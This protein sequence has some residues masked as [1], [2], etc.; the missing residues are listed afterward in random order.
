MLNKKLIRK[1]TL[2]KR[3]SIDPEKKLKKDKLIMERILSL[4]SFEKAKKVFYFASFRS[5]VST[6]PQIEEAFKMGKRIILPKVDNINNRLRL[7][8]IH[9]T[10]EIKPGFMGI[11]EPDVSLERERDINDV[12]LVIMPGVA[13]DTDGNR[14]GYGAGYYDKLLSGLKKD[15]PLIAIAYEE[16]IVDS[17]PVE[18]HDVRVHII[19]TDKRIIKVNPNNAQG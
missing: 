13:F 15:I 10:G 14:L 16:Q 19:V 5:E 17:L 1:K 4:P 3:D 7:F 9:N 12:D 11:P 8:E 6:L 2:I 18:S